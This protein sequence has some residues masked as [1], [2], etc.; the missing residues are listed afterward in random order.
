[1]KTK[2]NN[3]TVPHPL[4][5]VWAW[6]DAAYRATEEM[7]TSDALKLMHDDVAAVRKGFGLNVSEPR[8]GNACV[9]EAPTNYGEGKE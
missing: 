1:M 6:K 4:R 7:T 5:E 8:E 3:D 2:N 9:A